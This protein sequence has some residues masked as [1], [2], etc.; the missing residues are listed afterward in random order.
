MTRS[1][2][3]HVPRWYEPDPIL[4]ETRKAAWW[5]YMAATAALCI[6]AVILYVLVFG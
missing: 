6:A 2:R 5:P 4:D 1:G 3:H